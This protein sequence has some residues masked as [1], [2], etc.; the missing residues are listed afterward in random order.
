MK[1]NRKT[2]KFILKKDIADKN[3]HIQDMK[4]EVEESNIVS[5]NYIRD[6]LFKKETSI[7]L[8]WRLFFIFIPLCFITFGMNYNIFAVIIFLI[9]I[10]IAIECVITMVYKILNFD[11]FDS[12]EA[13]REIRL[14]L[15]KKNNFE[16]TK[17]SLEYKPHPIMKFFIFCQRYITIPLALSIILTLFVFSHIMKK[18]ELN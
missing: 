4:E 7:F 14:P 17:D 2:S 15:L 18:K 3:K 5:L 8:L 1:K 16:E 11:S 10:M 9:T 13:G 12:N 6:I